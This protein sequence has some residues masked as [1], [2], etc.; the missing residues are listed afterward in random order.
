[1]RQQLAYL[2]QRQRKRL[3]RSVR[4]RG[5]LEQVL[6]LRAVGHKHWEVALSQSVGVP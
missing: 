5:L 2:R 6:S 1:M 3:P 4:G